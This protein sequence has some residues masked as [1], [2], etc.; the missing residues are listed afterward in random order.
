[1][2][3]GVIGSYFVFFLVLSMITSSALVIDPQKPFTRAFAQSSDESIRDL[4]NYVILG[5]DETII[6][7]NVIINSGNVGVQNKNAQVTIKEGTTFMNSNSVLAGDIV[8]IELNANAQNVFFNDLILEG[9][10]L[11]SQNT[12]LAL[13]LVESFPDLSDIQTGT[14]SVSVA[15]DQTETLQPG[16]YD[17]IFVDEGATLI[18]VGGTYNVNS[19]ITGLNAKL[20]FDDV[21]EIVTQELKLGDNNILGPSSSASIDSSNIV[22]FV[23]DNTEPTMLFEIEIGKN[24]IIDANI[25]SPAGKLLVKQGTQATGSF[26]AKTVKIEDGSVLNID[27]AFRAIA[28]NNKYLDLVEELGKISD[29]ADESV[30][31]D[32]LAIATANLKTDTENLVTDPVARQNLVAI[33][34]SSLQNISLSGTKVLELD[35]A[36]ANLDIGNAMSD[37]ED[38][39]TQ[40]GL[41]SGT[42]IPT[43]TADLLISQA[44]Q[45]IS[46]SQKTGEEAVEIIVNTPLTVTSQIIAKAKADAAIMR[47]TV[48]EL[49]SL[50]FSVILDAENNSPTLTSVTFIDLVTL[51]QFDNIISDSSLAM[52]ITIAFF[53]EALNEGI[54][55]ADEEFATLMSVNPIIANNLINSN[56]VDASIIFALVA[57][58]PSHFTVE[59]CED[60]FANPGGI[61]ARFAIGP[62]AIGA[63]GSGIVGFIVQHCIRNLN[64]CITFI[65]NAI[66]LLLDLGLEGIDRSIP[67][68][69]VI[70]NVINDDVGSAVPGD[71]D[72]TVSGTNPTKST[73]PGEDGAGTKLRIGTGNYI[74]TEESVSGYTPT[75]VGC[76]GLFK[77]VQIQTCTITNDDEPMPTLIP[78]FDIVS[79]N[80]ATTITD[81]SFVSVVLGDGTGG[82]SAPS[83]FAAGLGGGISKVA[84]DDFNNDGNEDAIVTILES[85]T[86]PRNLSLLLGD[87]T[88]AFG[89]PSFTPITGRFPVGIASGDFNNDGNQDAAFVNNGDRTL[90][91]LLGDGAG[92]FGPENTF[93]TAHANPPQEMAVGDFNNDGNDDVVVAILNGN[94]ASV[95]IADGTGGFDPTILVN[96]GGLTPRDV[97]TF[98]FNNDGFDDFVVANA[99]TFSMS[100]NLFDD[101]TGGFVL[102][103][104]VSTGSGGSPRA[105]AAGDFNN[106]GN[107][108]VLTL[109]GGSRTFSIFSGDGTGNFILS[110]VLSTGSSIAPISVV[111]ADFNKDGNDDLATGLAFGNGMLINL[112]DG[113]GSFG[114]PT[115]FSL[116]PS[117]NRGILQVTDLNP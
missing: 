107:G 12:P 47:D 64:D 13:P 45:I 42:T 63:V 35:E 108:D 65:E 114:S 43:A 11:G 17:E 25:F 61:S 98:D 5:F 68:L 67:T 15:K 72:I 31:T 81:N 10:I 87:G 33:L 40:V 77:P 71:F 93:S 75:F 103:D 20:L 1:M 44:N 62:G 105:V 36:G 117:N 104:I 70:K 6:E 58:C 86:G 28:L 4:G 54:V 32:F 88:G 113:T 51:E 7:Q 50:G 3:M 101:A 22:I 109:N 115:L 110:S 23:H 39:V 41:L 97:E 8:K 112:G 73:F 53:E 85:S 79:V 60:S 84:I 52:F 78:D 94:V 66:P 76:E 29:I 92:G 69:F 95:F 89:P 80:E 14:T 116:G 37:L 90:S 27:S 56:D 91:V 21:T 74:V 96:I 26:I 82:F 48:N 30:I 55:Y 18:F 57:V 34:D 99:G 19:I 49:D 24:S 59:E 9:D 2:G 46:D 38:Y 111:V 102:S 16:S 100:V 106:D 83:A